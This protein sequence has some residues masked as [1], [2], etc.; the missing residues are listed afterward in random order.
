[1]RNAVR[2]GRSLARLVC[3]PVADYIRKM[4]L[5]SGQRSELGNPQLPAPQHSPHAHHAPETALAG[6]PHSP[7]SR[8]KVPELATTKTRR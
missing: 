1:V 5:Y 7:R 4:H 3:D 6:S 8:A 2:G